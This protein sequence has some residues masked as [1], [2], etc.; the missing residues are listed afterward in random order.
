[1][2]EKF[3]ADL[4]IHSPYSRAT[5]KNLQPELIDLWAKI[6][7]IKVVGTGDFTHPQWLKELEEKLKPEGEGLFVLKDEYKNRE[8]TFFTDEKTYFMLSGEISCIYKKNEKVRKIHSIIFVPDFETAKKLQINLEKLGNIKADGRPIFGLDVKELLDLILNI[9]ADCFLVPAHI[10][11]P[12]FSILG[13]NSGF[14]SIK[15]CFEEL[16]MYIFAI[17]TGLSSDPIMN[18]KCSM[19]DDF[20]IISN[21]DAHSLENLGR[22]ANIFCCELSYFSIRDALKNKDKDKFLGTIEF[23][24]Q[25]GKYHYDGHKKC[26]IKLDPTEAEKNNNLCPIC[27]KP[28]TLGVMHRVMQL[29]DRTNDDIKP[30]NYNNFFYL[31]PLIEII[32]EIIGSNKN[33]KK[34]IDI[35]FNLIKKLGSEIDILLNKNY[36]E[37]ATSGLPL[38]D[39]A[40]KRMR[41]KKVIIE[42]GYDGEYG[43]I[44]L[45]E[46][47]E[48][49]AFSNTLFNIPLQ[50]HKEQIKKE[51]TNILNSNIKNFKEINGVNSVRAKSIVY[52]EELNSNQLEIINSFNGPIIVI[53]GPG[54][55][56]TKTIVHKI[57][58]LIKNGQPPETIL[59]ITFSR[60]AAEEIRERVTSQLNSNINLNIHTFHS[61]GLSVIEENIEHTNRNKNYI[62]INEYDR[63]LIISQILNKKAKKISE[64]ISKIKQF[65]IENIEEE[66]KNI[67]IEYENYLKKNNLFDFDDLIYIPLKLFYKNKQILEYYQNRYSYIIVDEFQ[68]IN[69]AQFML[70]IALTKKEAPNITV[71]GDPLQAIYGFRGASNIFFYEFKKIFNNAKEFTLDTSYR[72]TNFILSAAMSS[73]QKTPYLKSIKE[74][75]KVNIIEHPT[76]KAEAEFIAREIEKLLGGVRFFSIDSNV[77]TGEN[78]DISFKDIAVLCRTSL[79]IPIIKKAFDDHSIPY[80]IVNE[81]PFYKRPPFIDILNIIKYFET[82]YD[83]YKYSILN[84]NIIKESELSNY[85]EIY[86]NTDLIKFIKIIFEDHFKD[87]YPEENNGL[88]RIEEIIKKLKTPNELFKFI[89]SSG[90]VDLLDIENEKVK[91]MTMHASKGLEFNTVFIPGCNELLI[92]FSIYKTYSIDIEEE[93]RLFYVALTRA[94]NLLYLTYPKKISIMNIKHEIPISPFVKNIKEELINFEKIERKKI[95]DDG[96]LSL[97]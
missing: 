26:Q 81:E 64:C 75:A 34:V 45:F 13:S 4:H 87:K 71:V 23:Y 85:N 32:S 21:S 38:L 65:S 77:T 2:R 91:I 80:E 55:G 40:I 39:E 27:K 95:K 93:K 73:I 89:E 79:Q 96:Q 84:S 50:T 17:E 78:T 47:N 7:G 18:W 8:A 51:K 72:C 56:K 37:I 66:I 62:I 12:W 97:F 92:P 54:T 49:N 28:I 57:L 16:T 25:E 10:W 29:A 52:N 41:E 24:P 61:F 42:E 1:M 58:A 5:S 60:H 63:E 69:R 20:T 31:I 76:E 74:G 70:T 94:K 30:N 6:K 88:K 82:G 90:A 53:A 48:L 86:K 36:S 9:N 22:E 3:I 33:S 59:T 14:D 46:K 44:T 43:K 15:E 67:F 35:Y 83:F 19:L 68:D 11:T